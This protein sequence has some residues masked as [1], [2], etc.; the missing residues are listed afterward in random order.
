MMLRAAALLGLTSVTIAQEAAIKP[1]PAPPPPAFGFSPVLGDY[2]VLQR[3]PAAAA[4]YGQVLPGTTA[5]TVTVSDGTTSYDVKATV[6]KDATHQ[7][8]GYVDPGTG[9]NL[10]V[11][12]ETWKA[13]L[14]PAAAGGDYTI[15]AV[16]DDT[17]KV[18]IRNIAEF[19]IENAHFTPF[20]WPE[21][22]AR[23]ARID[24][25]DAGARDL[26]S[27]I[28]LRFLEFSDEKM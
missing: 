14:K 15:T 11:V 7:P 22:S 19:N 12:N 8:F 4:V 21:N 1:P 18:T 24:D 2:M 27:A 20:V 10:P 6:G 9:A 25:G 5:V 16:A 26:W 23:F 28:W 17:N 3:A 13:I